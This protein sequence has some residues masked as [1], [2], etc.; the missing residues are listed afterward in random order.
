MHRDQTSSRIAS[1]A[2]LDEIEKLAGIP[3][4]VRQG[5]GGKMGLLLRAKHAAGAS[6]AKLRARAAKKT[7]AG[8][9][10]WAADGPYDDYSKSDR[11]ES[12]GRSIAGDARK[13][14]GLDYLEGFGRA[15]DRR[16]ASLEKRAG[17]KAGTQAAMFR[18]IASHA[19]LD[20]IEKLAGVRS[21]I[22]HHVGS[23]TGSRLRA[24]KKRFV[25]PGQDFFE[26]SKAQDDLLRE[27]MNT[28]VARDAALS[29]L[30][31][32]AAVGGFGGIYHSAKK[33]Q[34]AGNSGRFDLGRRPTKARAPGMVKKASIKDQ[35]RA[36]WGAAKDVV[37]RHRGKFGLGAGL[38]LGGAGGA[39]GG[40]KMEQNRLSPQEARFTAEVA[41]RAGQSGYVAGRRSQF[42]ELP[43][44]VRTQIM[45][46]AAK[47][48]SEAPADVQAIGKT[49]KARGA[50]YIRNPATGAVYSL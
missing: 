13:A 18:R 5:G 11:M 32:L 10:H 29:G 4:A 17:R 36:A 39:Y 31:G 50:K 8:V 34:N 45:A 15:M 37:G 6:A 7:K 41:R 42:S 30:A 46:R 43:K 20:E 1:H 38:A 28:E 21:S 19:Q 22:K 49:M 47:P 48:L 12:A 33:R 14:M 35:A 27:Y 24:A 23:L 9:P 16:V 2:Q 40:Y 25:A 26:R 44:D 3:R